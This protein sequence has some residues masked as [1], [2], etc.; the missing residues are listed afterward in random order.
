MFSFAQIEFRKISTNR[1]TWIL[2]IPDPP[3]DSNPL[4]SCG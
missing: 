4:G 2:S 1:I 3:Y